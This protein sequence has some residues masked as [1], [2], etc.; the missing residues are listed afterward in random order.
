M[1]TTSKTSTI[2]LRGNRSGSQAENVYL[3]TRVTR[4][5][6]DGDY[7]YTV[8]ILQHRRS[9]EGGLWHLSLLE[10]EILETQIRH[11]E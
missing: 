1:V 10:L 4:L 7:Q 9:S 2:S 5:G 3:S 11:L 8:D 6:P